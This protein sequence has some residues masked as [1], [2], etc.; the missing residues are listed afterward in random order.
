MSA[1]KIGDRKINSSGI[2]PEQEDF[3]HLQERRE[4]PND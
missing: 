1:N 4:R 3:P 2:N